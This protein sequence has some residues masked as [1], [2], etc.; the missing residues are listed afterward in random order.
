MLRQLS[1]SLII[2]ALV[3]C[4]ASQSQQDAENLAAIQVNKLTKY[5]PMQSDG[6]TL[7]VANKLVSNIKLI[8]IQDNQQKPNDQSP[9]QFLDAYKIQMCRS[10]EIR[11]LLKKGVTYTITVNSLQSQPVGQ[12]ALNSKSCS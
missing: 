1:C 6:Y 11:H 3:G 7:V 12:L 4:A 9:N 5:L 8:F 10:D 2:L